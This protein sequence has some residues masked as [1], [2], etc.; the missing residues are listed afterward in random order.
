MAGRAGREVYRSPRWRE[1]RAVVLE[2][3]GYRC[4]GCGAAGRLE[5]DHVT[6]LDRGGAA[7]DE[8]NLQALCRACH[9]GKTLAESEQ[10]RLVPPAVVAWREFAAELV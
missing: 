1:V 2:R 5:V 6:P 4:R 3:D 7:F 10:R 9:I 8:N